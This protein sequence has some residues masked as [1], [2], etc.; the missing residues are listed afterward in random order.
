[1][2]VMAQIEEHLKNNGPLDMITKILDEYK[3]NI[4]AE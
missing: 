2:S 4:N 1:M 3:M